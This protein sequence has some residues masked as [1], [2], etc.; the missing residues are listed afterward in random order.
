VLEGAPAVG[1]AAA[2]CAM[3]SVCLGNFMLCTL[4]HLFFLTYYCMWT[5]PSRR[6]VTA[7]LVPNSPRAKLLT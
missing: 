5:L 6:T 2:A 7:W 1:M 4:C 3:S